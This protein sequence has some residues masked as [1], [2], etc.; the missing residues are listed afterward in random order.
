MLRAI[1]SFA[2]VIVLGLFIEGTLLPAVNSYVV[3]PDILLALVVVLG[4]Y[5]R[6]LGGLL[7]A[8]LV[9]LIS[10]FSSAKYVGV[11][12]AGAIMAFWVV[13]YI[14]QKVY[15]EHFVGLVILGFIASLVE[16]LTYVA[17]IAPLDGFELS[18][19]ELFKFGLWQAAITAAF[20]PFIIYFIRFLDNRRDPFFAHKSRA[21]RKY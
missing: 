16:Q 19:G 18:Y 1:L 17:I 9:G 21:L 13:V 14:S 11:E 15:I 3:V 10:D 12:A 20:T 8:L 7:A 2:V 4:L 6:A 5:F